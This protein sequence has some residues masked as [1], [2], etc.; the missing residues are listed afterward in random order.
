MYYSPFCR[1]TRPVA[2]TFSLDL[3]VLGT[4][5][6]LIL[7][8]DQTLQNNVCHSVPHYPVFKELYPSSRI[9][10]II[11]GHIS[12]NHFFIILIDTHKITY[13]I[14]FVNRF[15]PFLKNIFYSHCIIGKYSYLY[16]RYMMMA[17]II[18]RVILIERMA[19]IYA[20]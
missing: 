14:S 2:R 18:N 3:H 13:F 5:P 15:F 19:Y 16:N 7:S 6:S 4:P 10:I 12:S 17:K 20:F 11:Q 9:F 1:F 8:Q